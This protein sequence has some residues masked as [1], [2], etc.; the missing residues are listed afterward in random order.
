[1]AAGARV[2]LADTGG[3]GDGSLAV[4][5]LATLLGD[6]AFHPVDGPRLRVPQAGLLSTVSEEQRLRALD[7]ERH[8][9]EVETSCPVP[10][11][12]T[13]GRPQYDPASTTPAEREQARADELAAQGWSR[14]SRATVRRWRSRNHAGGVWGLAVKRRGATR[15]DRADPK[16]VEALRALLPQEALRSRYRGWKK[17]MRRETQWWLDAQHGVGVVEVPAKSTFNKLIDAVDASLGLQGTVVQRRA[18]AARPT[19]PF[20]PTLALW[21]GELVM[22]DSSPLDAL[23]VLD[24]RWWDGWS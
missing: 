13:V 12:K 5:G 1:M 23:V 21:P 11:G 9:R 7:L 17:R 24:D 16:T 4:F 19:P 8:V 18:R 20:K 6:P 2:W 22:M 10:D 14:V 15:L 3:D